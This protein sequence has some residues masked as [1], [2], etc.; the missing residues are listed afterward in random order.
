MAGMFV[1]TRGKGS[2]HRRII[3]LVL[4]TRH[5][6]HEPSRAMRAA[7]HFG[8]EDSNE[9]NYDPNLEAEADIGSEAY[10]I[11]YGIPDPLLSGQV[12]L[13]QLMK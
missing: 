13:G 11:A 8:D 5:P 6:S 9:P 1:K 10:E 12:A 7:G 2:P 4:G 3:P